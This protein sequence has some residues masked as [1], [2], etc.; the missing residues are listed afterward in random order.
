[1]TQSQQHTNRNIRLFDRFRNVIMTRHYSFRTEQSYW[2]WT[3]RYILYHGK[4]HPAEM[5]TDEISAFLT[6]LAVE[7]NVASATQN[8]ALNALLFLYKQV[9]EIDL[10]KIQ[11]IKR[12]KRQARLPVVLTRDEIRSVLGRM[13]HREWL[14]ASLMYGS[15]LR[16]RECLQLRVKDV[17]FGYRQIVVRQGKGGKD[18]VT[19]LPKQLIPPLKEQLEQVR[20]YHTADKE[21]G[22]GE[23]SLPYALARKYP[24][25][26]FDWGWQ[27]VFPA[28]KRS[29]DP[30]SKRIKRH[31]IDNSVIQKALR[32]AVRSAGLSKRVTCHSL[33]HS[34]ATHLLESGQDIRTIQEIMGH[35]DV[36]TTMIYTHVL[37]L[38]GQGV[39]SPLDSTGGIPPAV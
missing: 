14:M 1:M 19:P 3:K 37:G 15:G 20:R 34:F 38:G 8:Q 26:G 6:Y 17:D 29:V 16:L 27:Y 30:H 36:R 7:R 10:P 12:A 39:P 23:T 28:S 35:K 25:A 33:R 9:L 11:G 5:G 18:R 32:S 13:R 31:H 2:H 22:F 21:D 24:N 4:R